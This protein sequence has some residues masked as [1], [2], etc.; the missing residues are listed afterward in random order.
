MI[1]M[2]RYSGNNDQCPYCG[3][4][5]RDFRCTTYTTFQEVKDSLWVDSEDSDDWKYK[6]KGTVLGRWHMAKQHEWEEHIELCGQYLNTNTKKETSDDN[7]VTTY[8]VINY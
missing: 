5:Y 1:K 6:R 7:D 2:S 8:N 3:I 4:K